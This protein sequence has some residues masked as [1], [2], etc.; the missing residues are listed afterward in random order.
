MKIPHFDL[1]I[2]SRTLVRAS[3]PP[4]GF[5]A[6]LAVSNLDLVLGP[7]PIF[8][9]SIYAAP[10]AGLD[11]VVSAVRAA[12]PSYLSSFYPFAGRVVRDPETN[13]PAV[14]CTN[15]GAELV[16]ADAAVP[17]AAVD[18]AEVDASL[19]LIQIP[20]DASLP[21]SVQLVRFACGGFAL[22]VATS[23]LLADGRAFAVLLTALA[24]TVRDGRPSRDPVFDRSLF[25]PR[26]RHG[27]GGNA[28]ATLDAEFARFAP[29]AWSTR[30]SPRPCGGGC[31]ASTR[32]T[33]PRSRPRPP[34]SRAA[35]RGSWR[36]ARTCGS[37]WRARW[38]TPTR[39]AGWRGSWRGGRWWSPCTARW[40]GTSGTW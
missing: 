16:V 25:R 10:A 1:E 14:A 30:S 21:L 12:L 2:A 15:A 8:L 13:I 17:L 7:F 3:R 6:E 24:E 5:P 19:G 18:F 31:T 27:G 20:F 39:G 37:S 33:S 38:A 4:P 40:T 26:A 22:T 34:P 23:H 35:R 29:E 28:A 32:P 11:A 9:I 36:C